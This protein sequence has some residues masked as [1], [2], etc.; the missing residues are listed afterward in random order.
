MIM[1]TLL[2]FVYIE[3]TYFKTKDYVGK[4][5]LII[6]PTNLLKKQNSK[7]D[8]ALRAF[9]VLLKVLLF[10]PQLNFRCIF[11]VYRENNKNCS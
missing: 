2:K 11:P 1:Y 9:G 8:V 3:I 4:C 5:I 6:S 7:E 10:I